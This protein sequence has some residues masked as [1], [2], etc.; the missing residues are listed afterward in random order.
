MGATTYGHFVEGADLHRGYTDLVAAERAQYGSDPYSGSIAA[1]YGGVTKL[2]SQVCHRGEAER[3]AEALL[4]GELGYDSPAAEGQATELLAALGG[5]DGVPLPATGFYG[6]P[7]GPRRAADQLP[8]FM[9][10]KNGES[11]AIPVGFD[12][13]LPIRPHGVP[14][15]LVTLG[16]TSHWPGQHQVQAA[17]RAATKGARIASVEVLEDTPAWRTVTRKTRGRAVTE[18]VVYEVTE[19]GQRIPVPDLS[20]FATVTD[21]L[22]AAELRCATPAPDRFGGQ[23]RP[24]TLEVLGQVRREG[25]EALIRAERILTSRFVLYNVGIVTPT[26]ST[27]RIRGWWVFGTA[28]T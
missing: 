9:R 6:G 25:G 20:P 7:R 22:E 17:I 19:R 21:A 14:V 1:S 18:Y 5:G 13:E 15:D 24:L 16:L 4:D 12:D 27:P 11:A 3:L 28:G 8:Q 2:T 23:P 26:T 10:E